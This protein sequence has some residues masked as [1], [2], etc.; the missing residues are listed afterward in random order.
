MSPDNVILYVCVW[1]GL[2]LAVQVLLGWYIN[3]YLRRPAPQPL[4][5]DECP[6]ALVL[7]CLRGGDPFLDHTLSGL[8][9][10]DY[11]NYRIRIVVDS[12][13]DQAHYYIEQS[14]GCPPP[15]NVEVLTLEERFS[16]CTYKLSGILRGT[17]DLPE[18]VAFVAAPGWRHDS[19]CH[20]AAG[21]GLPHRSRRSRCL[22]RK[23]VV[24]P[25][26][27]AS[28]TCSASSGERGPC[29]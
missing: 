29:R 10:Q 12:A 16:T 11:P 4:A 9:R 7:L 15:A 22:H 24:L 6:P 1:L 8:V 23:P 19:A 26:A 27:P 2:L 17:T 14:L 21:T 18:D 20:L 3:R 5:D 13:E 25:A 28:R